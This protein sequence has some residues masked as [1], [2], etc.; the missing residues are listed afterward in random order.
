M[1]EGD[2]YYRGAAIGLA[3]HR[4]TANFCFSSNLKKKY[5]DILEK[6]VK[7][8]NVML[9]DFRFTTIQFNESYKMAKHVDSRNAGVSYIIGLG[10]YTGGSC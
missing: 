7:L 9:P 10:D 2:T 6:A 3:R 5:I 4:F 1:K 8:C